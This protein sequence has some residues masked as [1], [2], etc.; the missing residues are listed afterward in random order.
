MAKASS[1]ED[2]TQWTL[3]RIPPEHIVTL[4]YIVESYEGLAILRTLNRQEAQVVLLHPE[5]S[6]STLEAILL[7]L[8]KEFPLERLPLPESVPEEWYLSDAE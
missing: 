7:E 2:Q 1:D 3:L 8:E 5:S 6:A 4:K